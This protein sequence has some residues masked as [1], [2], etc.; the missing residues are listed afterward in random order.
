[1]TRFRVFLLVVLG[2][3]TCLPA[4]VTCETQVDSKAWGKV[5]T[6]GPPTPAS[7]EAQRAKLAVLEE[8]ARGLRPV[9]GAWL[10]SPTA[11]TPVPGPVAAG[12][13]RPLSGAEL[14]AAEARIRAK[15][16]A[17]ARPAPVSPWLGPAG[18]LPPKP[19]ELRTSVPLT[20]EALARSLAQERAKAVTPGSVRRSP[21]APGTARPGVVQDGRKPSGTSI[22]GTPLNPEQRAKLEAARAGIAPTPQDRP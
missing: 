1:M 2:L 12:T 19:R 11:A 21:A 13:S 4:A 15:L 9:P 16:A 20:G 6:T 18:P 22:P 17:T 8:L 5:S 14:A 7:A 10:S 3:A